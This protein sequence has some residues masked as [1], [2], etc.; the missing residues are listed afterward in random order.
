MRTAAALSEHPLATH[1]V[2]ECV[3]ALL[4]QGGSSPDLLVLFVTAPQIGVF[5][6]VVAASRQ[7][8]DP[9]VTL[10]ASS[11]S[12]LAG[13][14]EVEE[15]S[16]I[17]AFGLW[18]DDAAQRQPSPPHAGPAP[19][20][21][22][23]SSRAGPEGPEVVGLDT[24]AGSSGTLVLLADPFSC[25]VDLIIEELAASAPELAV[26]GGLASAARQPG[27]NRLVLDDGVYADGAVG[28]LLP[29]RVGVT[30]VVSQ[31]CR[32]IGQPLTVTAGE[33]N[34]VAELAGRPALERLLDVVGTL[35][36]EDRQ[37]AAQGMQVGR[38]IDEQRDEFGRGDFLI[39]AVVGADRERGVVAIDDEV[40]LGA[41]LQFQLRDAAAAHDDL[42]E[43]LG[44]RAAA[45]ALV[46]TC[47]GRGSALFG[48]PD[49]DATVVSES[50]A[51][52]PVAGMFCAG[53]FGP[54]GGV[55]FVHG[56][57]ASVLL[58]E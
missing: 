42:V 9:L 57:S 20:A 41:T 43:L 38:V 52:A 24:L 40:E 13:G 17:A 15:H 18:D 14:R 10:G 4:E 19:R 31:G 37:L 3:G 58:F 49:H 35:S 8:L 33:R 6:D 46:F 45:G 23:L 47:N 36:P 21:V 22:R 53:E 5:E 55:N 11:V 48:I 28:V 27:G 51:G 30:T 50:L 26:V 25:P 56:F 2:G 44:E 54:V 32:P 29:D 7:V 39:R 1:A 16:A 12:V 34:L